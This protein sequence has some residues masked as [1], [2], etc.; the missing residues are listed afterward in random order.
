MIK[1]KNILSE[2][3][4]YLKFIIEM[5]QREGIAYKIFCDQQESHYINLCDQVTTTCV[6]VKD[7]L[8]ERNCF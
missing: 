4:I 8:K 3:K 7:H 5:T 2:M 1:I 6:Q